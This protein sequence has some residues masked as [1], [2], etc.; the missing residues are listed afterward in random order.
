MTTLGAILPSE[1]ETDIN[2]QAI[3]KFNAGSRSGTANITAI[4]GGVASLRR[5]AENLDRHSSR[6][7]GHRQC[8]PADGARDRRLGDD[9]R[10]GSRCERQ[11]VGLDA[12]FVFNQCGHPEHDISYDGP[13]WERSGCPHDLPN[14]DRNG[15]CG[16][17]GGDAAGHDAATRQRRH[18]SDNSNTPA[19]AGQASGSVTVNVAGAPTLQIALATGTTTVSAGLPASFT[20]TVGAATTNPNPIRDVTV[21]WGDR[22]PIQHLGAVGTGTATG[23]TVSHVFSSPGTYIVTGTVIDTFGTVTP[24]SISVTVNPKP[25][26]GV[27][28]TV[29]T[30][31]PTAGSDVAF[32]ASVAASSGAPGTVIQNV[33]VDFGDGTTTPLGAATGTTISLHHVYQTAGT[34]TVT[35]KA[36]DSNGGEGTAVTTIFVQ[37][38]TPLGVSITFQR[39][40]IDANNTS[41][42]FTAT[43]T[44]LGNAVVTQYQWDFGDG[45][46]QVTTTNQVTHNYTKP[47][48]PRQVRVLVTVSDG[49]TT[50]GTA[51]VTP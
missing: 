49:R 12:G 34:Y 43:V 30:T 6:R 20:F 25:Q 19:A 9:Q 31:N 42:A 46:S 14:G 1:T 15:K 32:T 13:G 47:A 22:S 40:V 17:D 24:A 36:T 18:N 3:V 5:R 38:A 7:Q 4:S 33:T 27:T 35:L 26:P 16:R 41:V 39:T 48:P 21:D 8:D 11:P 51:T 28:L 10:L 45:D 23:L 29:T 37:A 50:S 2:G 44:G